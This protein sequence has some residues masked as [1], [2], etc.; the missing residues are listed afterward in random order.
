MRRV[1][2]YGLTGNIA[3]GKSTVAR[4]FSASGVPVVDADKVAREVALPGKPALEEIAQRFPG[5]L[6]PDG[7]LD[8]KALAARVFTDA[9]ERAA[10]NQIM[11]PRIAAEVAARLAALAASG[12]PFAIYEAALLVENGLHRPGLGLDGL[13]VV[14]A[15]VDEQVRR[16][17]VRDGLSEPEAR[18]RIAAQLPAAEKV[19]HA[20]FVVANAG[21]AEALILE[22]RPVLRALEAG[23][24]RA[25][26][27]GQ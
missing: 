25:P 6:A 20:D 17:G 21:S 5:V 10:L 14:T 7:S 24:R 19:A 23:Y 13:I 9:A 22:V 18:A 12:E 3:S 27:V 2:V 8:R 26:G 1:R 11:H 4:I 15:P 16:I